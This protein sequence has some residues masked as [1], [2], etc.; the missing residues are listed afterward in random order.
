M[1]RRRLWI[2]LLGI[3]LSLAVSL[4]YAAWPGHSTF[5]VSPETTYVT[6]PLD[7]HGCIDYVTAINERLR[8]NITPEANANVLIWQALGPRPE[9][10]EMPPEYFTWLGIDA[11]PEKGDYAVRFADYLKEHGKIEGSIKLDE[12]SDRMQRA[13]RWPWTPKDEPELADWLQRSEKPLALVIEASRRP[14]YYNPLVPKT[15]NG[16]SGALIESLLPNVQRCR[17]LATELASRAIL[18]AS[19]GEVNAAWKDLLACHRLGRL[20]ARD[21]GTLIQTLVGIAMELIAS[22]AD[23]VFLES[24]ALTSKQILVCLRDLQS[25]G[26]LPTLADKIDLTERFMCLDSMLLVAVRGP[27]G[28]SGSFRGP[29]KDRFPDRLFSRNLNWDLALRNANQVYDRCVAAARMTDR[30]ARA[31]KFDQIA[32]DVAKA[33]QEVEDLDLI[34]KVSMGPKRRG[35]TIG[36]IVI[37]MFLPAVE[38]VYGAIDRCEQT[39]RNLHLAFALAAYQRDHGK[40]PAALSDLAPKYS[41]KIPDDL[42]SGKPLIYRPAGDGYL[43]YSVGPNGQDDEGRSNDD[44]PRGDDLGVRVPVPEPKSKN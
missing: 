23:I 42:F 35:E 14:E 13:T 5:T 24:P 33:R 37:A 6:G 40:Y 41:D 31:Q 12:I 36:H 28:L 4:I 3:F 44:E 32:W 34:Q 18:R 11:P 29:P 27:D 26:P 7:A 43:L 16:W 10:G 1:R 22:K 20:M 19:N 15:T 8:G 17:E 21:G 39:Q 9:G 2:T 30:D 25:L 38:K